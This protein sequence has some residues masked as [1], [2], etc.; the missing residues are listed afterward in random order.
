MQKYTG[1]YWMVLAPLVKKSLKKH[2]GTIIRD[3]FG[4]RW[5]KCEICGIIKQDVEFASYG[6]T[7]HINL[8][9]CRECCRR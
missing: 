2:Y 1:K 3:R 5:V 8:G 4:N 6:G 7:N 9:T